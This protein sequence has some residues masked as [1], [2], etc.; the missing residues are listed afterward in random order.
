MKNILKAIKEAACIN[1]YIFMLGFM[2]MA[3]VGYSNDGELLGTI[4]CICG[5]IICCFAIKQETERT[6][7]LICNYEED[8]EKE[9]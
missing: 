2:I 9:D 8:D 5:A 6:E 7:N 4:T 3:A 1:A